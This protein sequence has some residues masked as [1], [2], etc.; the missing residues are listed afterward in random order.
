MT[1]YTRSSNAKPPTFCHGIDTSSPGAPSCHHANA[2]L[3]MLARNSDLEGA[4]QAVREMEDRFNRNYNYPWVFLNE[5]PFSSDFKRCVFLPRNPSFYGFFHVPDSGSRV[6]HTLVAC[7]SSPLGLCILA[8]SPEN[9]GISL[10]GSTKQRRRRR[11][12]RWRRRVSSTVA[13]YRTAFHFDCIV[14]E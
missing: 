2:T 11:E 9:I 1:P 5:E 6:S 13:V 7:R 8:W 4:V 14:S 10:I 12:K 3:V